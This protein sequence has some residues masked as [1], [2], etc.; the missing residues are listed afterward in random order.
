MRAQL[1]GKEPSRAGPG[2]DYPHAGVEEGEDHPQ[3]DTRSP[4]SERGSGQTP[5]ARSF[6][7]L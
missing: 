2:G 6:S 3:G 7:A 4:W 1:E 5:K